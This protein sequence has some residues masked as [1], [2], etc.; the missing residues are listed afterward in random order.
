MLIDAGR[1]DDISLKLS[2]YIPFWD[3]SLD[4]VIATHPD[5]DHITGFNALLNEYPIGM[6]FHSGLLAGSPIYR[7]IAQK[8][9]KYHIPAHSLIAGEKI[10]LDKDMYF[11]VLS[12]HKNKK[13]EDANDYSVVVR[14]VYQGKAIMLTGD[15]PQ[16][17]E[18]NLVKLYGKQR[19]VSEVLK[20][21]HHGSKT[22]SADMFVKAVHPR[23]G[24]VSA[25]CHNK[26]GHPHASTLRT[27]DKN[28]VEE[29]NTCEHGDI[30][31]EFQNGHW[32]LQ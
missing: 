17:V 32:E 19:L 16:S 3:R 13:I 25:G 10:F 11:E 6:F 30:V 1:Y 8:V 7:S 14:L 4:F 9:Q 24:I 18:R 31:F 5:I 21:G 23:Y 12:P 22:S 29:I 26:Y 27:L 2:P 20:L 28:N 15:A